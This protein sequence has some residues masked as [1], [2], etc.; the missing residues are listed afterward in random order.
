MWRSIDGM[1]SSK[2]VRIKKFTNYKFP[3]LFINKIIYHTLRNIIKRCTIQYVI[4]NMGIG[5]VLVESNP[6]VNTSV[7]VKRN[8]FIKTKCFERTLYI[9]TQKVV[10]TA[11]ID[12]L[13][14]V[15]AFALHLDLYRNQ[16]KFPWLGAI[17]H[18]DYSCEYKFS[19][20]SYIDR[21]PIRVGRPR[22]L[23]PSIYNE[24][25]IDA[26]DTYRLKEGFEQI[27]LKR[28]YKR[29]LGIGIDL[30]SKSKYKDHNQLIDRI[31]SY[32]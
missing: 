10:Y 15:G 26:A 25:D 20:T 30:I 6:L 9:K 31:T 7:F 14:N 2:S 23:A 22:Y 27:L 5:K 17:P 24:F 12:Y 3:L 8:G 18:V 11:R 1:F 21:T 4:E 29:L 19:N 16:S 28:D 13:V 32:I